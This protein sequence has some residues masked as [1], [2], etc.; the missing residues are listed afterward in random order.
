V[1]RPEE[2]ESRNLAAFSYYYDRAVDAAIIPASGGTVSVH[3]F[4]QVRGRI[5]KKR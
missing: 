2:L 5:F 1:D 4:T 3:N